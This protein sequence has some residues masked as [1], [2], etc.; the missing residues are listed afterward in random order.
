MTDMSMNNDKKWFRFEKVFLP[1]EYTFNFPDKCVYCGNEKYRSIKIEEIEN[2]K[3]KSGLE[4]GSLI[5]KYMTYKY[6]FLIPYC[7][8]HFIITNI[9]R[10]IDCVIFGI[11]M[12]LFGY[13]LWIW[14]Q[15]H[16]IISAAIDFIILFLLTAA[17]AGIFYGIINFFLSKVFSIFQAKRIFQLLAIDIEISNYKKIVIEFF[18]SSVGKEFEQQFKKVLI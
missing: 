11:G 3:I 16:T 12:V 2:E 15:D 17:A 6:I 10:A 9:F 14:F 18:N 1:G 13:P 4:D 8:R 5:S 7:K